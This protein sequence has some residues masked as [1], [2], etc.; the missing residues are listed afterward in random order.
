MDNFYTKQFDAPSKYNE[1][2]LETENFKVIPSLGSLVEGWV[3]VVPKKHYLSF[4]YLENTLFIELN[5][6]HKQ[7]I[8][9]LQD[10]F[11][12]DVI[13]FENG[14][15]SKGSYLGCGVDYAHMHYVP[16]EIDLKKLVNEFYG[17]KVVWERISTL[18]SMKN[19][20]QNSKPYLFIDT[21]IRDKFICEIHEPYSQLIRKFIAN[22]IGKSNQ[23]DWKRF[24]FDD[25]IEKTI[26]IFSSLR[27]LNE[28]KRNFNK[29]NVFQ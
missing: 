22:E 12:K 23:Y 10:L 7:V 8:K 21:N 17:G 11:R 6:L 13:A 27:P 3:L 14:S 16:L 2:L 26:K 28:N 24:R 1:P 29:V 5:Y 15:L 19:K 18:V 9:I 20:I 4:G 25:N